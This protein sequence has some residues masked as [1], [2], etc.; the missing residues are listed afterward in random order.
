M[1]YFEGNRYENERGDAV[2][3]K[4]AVAFAKSSELVFSAHRA[5]LPD[6]DLASVLVA[7]VTRSSACKAACAYLVERDREVKASR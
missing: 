5:D 2:D 1:I 4:S 3:I 7:F 6:N